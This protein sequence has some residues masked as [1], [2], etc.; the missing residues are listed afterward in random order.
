MAVGACPLQ[1]ESQERKR[2]KRANFVC[3]GACVSQVSVL[4]VPMSVLANVLFPD[5]ANR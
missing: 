4:A 5:V 3:S 1:Q 2:A